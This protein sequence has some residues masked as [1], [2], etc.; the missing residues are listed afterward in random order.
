ML[1]HLH[2]FKLSKTKVFYIISIL[3]TLYANIIMMTIKTMIDNKILYN[4]IF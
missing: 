1:F 4:F 2:Q 3:I